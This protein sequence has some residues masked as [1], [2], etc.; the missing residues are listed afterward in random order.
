MMSTSLQKGLLEIIEYVTDT[1]GSWPGYISVQINMFFV[2]LSII[3]SK[4][5]WSLTWIKKD[6][7]DCLR[8]IFI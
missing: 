3:A 8:I 7:A 4:I 6:H 5:P 1:T 2:S